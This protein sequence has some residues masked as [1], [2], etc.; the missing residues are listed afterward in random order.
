MTS[1]QAIIGL[2][3]SPRQAERILTAF[4]GA[5][6]SKADVSVLL[7]NEPPAVDALAVRTGAIAVAIPGAGSFIAAGPILP[8]LS[9]ELIGAGSRSIVAMLIGLGTREREAEY[10]EE[11]VL[12]GRV[13][14]CVHVDE[15][16]E[17]ALARAIL[18]EGR[19]AHISSV[20][21]HNAST[22]D[23]PNAIR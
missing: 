7:P 15:H 5:G 13:L 16:E 9:G 3:A 18:L 21:E 10:Y 11:R 14:V 17:R 8:G 4:E 19:A 12:E 23:A 6:L 1:K 2:A 22:L 20:G